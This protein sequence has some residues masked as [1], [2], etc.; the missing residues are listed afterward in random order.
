MKSLDVTSYKTFVSA[1]SFLLE[2]LWATHYIHHPTPKRPKS[3]SKRGLSFRKNLSELFVKFS[4]NFFKI[5]SELFQN[6]FVTFSKFF[7]DFFQ[8]SFGFFIWQK[9]KL[10]IKRTTALKEET[11]KTRNKRRPPNRRNTYSEETTIHFIRSHPKRKSHF[12]SL[13]LQRHGNIIGI[14]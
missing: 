9:I 5:L 8:K 6:S 10:L 14:D 12:F 7:R 2:F 3:D 13:S 4:R 1:S 11:S